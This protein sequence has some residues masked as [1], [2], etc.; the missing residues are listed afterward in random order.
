MV[1]V[2]DAIAKRRTVRRFKQDEIPLETLK[3]LVDAARVAP[4]GAN[5]Q[6]LKY[7]IV[8]SKKLVDAIFPL[9]AW[10]GYIAPKGNPPEGERPTAYIIILADTNIH[11]G[12]CGHDVGAAAENLMLA[13]MAEGIG[14]CW[15]GA[16]DRPQIAEVLQIPEHLKI[17]TLISLG[18]PAEAPLMEEMTDSIKY[19]KD[20]SGTLHV[21]KRSLSEILKIM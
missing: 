14:T 18:L 16:I 6:P 17:D 1:D 12:D 20:S 13:A 2:Y 3:R 8:R 7:I 5:L 11:K 15:M 10:A 9:V 21:P 4:S 19:Y